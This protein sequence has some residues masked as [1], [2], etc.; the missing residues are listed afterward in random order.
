M[1][2]L[3]KLIYLFIFPG[4]IFTVLVGLFLSGL[5]RKIVAR[6]QRR[7]GP[8]ITQP[9]YDFAKLLGKDTIIPRNA[10]ERLFTLAP[11]IALVSICIIQYYFLY[12]IGH[13]LVVQL[14]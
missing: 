4:F 13:F 3:S 7:R 9:F 12:I 6:M 2:Y 5:D 8:K 11:I 10:N 1:E 14:I